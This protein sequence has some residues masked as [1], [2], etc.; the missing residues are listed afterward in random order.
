[1]PEKRSVYLV[2]VR[3]RALCGDFLIPP[4]EIGMTAN[5]VASNLPS[6]WPYVVMEL[7]YRHLKQTITW[8]AESRSYLASVYSGPR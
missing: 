3:A 5:Q 1:M 8:L 2:S 4:P 7:K 6:C